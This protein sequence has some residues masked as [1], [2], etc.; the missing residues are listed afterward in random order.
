MKHTGLCMLCVCCRDYCFKM[1]FAAVDK[2]LI[3][4]SR[5]LKDS[6]TRRFFYARQHLMLR[7]S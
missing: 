2:Q 6:D 1:A 4:S 3:K 5:Q 7:A